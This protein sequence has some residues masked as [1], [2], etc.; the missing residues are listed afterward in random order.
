MTQLVYKST[1]NIYAY[2]DGLMT[3]QQRFMFQRKAVC[4]VPVSWNWMFQECLRFCVYYKICISSWRCLFLHEII[5]KKLFIDAGTTSLWLMKPDRMKSRIKN[6]KIC[7]KNSF[8]Y[9][10]ILCLREFQIDF[11]SKNISRQKRKTALCWNWTIVSL[12]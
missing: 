8:L 2:H 11:F 10:P 4:Y 6:V 9:N 5:K 7:T 3:Q 12:R 1:R